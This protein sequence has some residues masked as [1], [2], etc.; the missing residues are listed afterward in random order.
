MF[1]NFFRASIWARIRS[2][3]NSPKSRSTIYFI[4]E[5]W[6]V[7]FV[8]ASKKLVI[9]VLVKIAAKTMLPCLISW[10]GRES[11]I[12]I[13]SL[14]CF[15]EIDRAQL[16]S[17][18]RNYSLWLSYYCTKLPL[19]SSTDLSSILLSWIFSFTIPCECLTIQS[20]I[21]FI[22]EFLSGHWASYSAII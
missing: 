19:I 10:L 4:K 13:K 17:S 3:P 8:R 16:S 6:L 12:S 1:G 11:S 7:N 15:A 5:E 22:V 9:L 20:L 18:Y 14:K 21:W 2:W